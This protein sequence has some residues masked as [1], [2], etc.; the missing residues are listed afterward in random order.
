MVQI[1]MIGYLCP[2]Y[3]LELKYH[4]H[5]PLHPLHPQPAPQQDEDL[6]PHPSREYQ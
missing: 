4:R 3:L 5:P 1:Q 6:E 2:A